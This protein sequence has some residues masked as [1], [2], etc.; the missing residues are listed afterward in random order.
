[1]NLPKGERESYPPNRSGVI[2]VVAPWWGQRKISGEKIL[3]LSS[4]FKSVANPAGKVILLFV[5]GRA[6]AIAIRAKKPVP[7]SAKSA[8]S[9]GE[10]DHLTII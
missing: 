9:F 5:E 4:I 10:A 3:S 8:G 1:M 2:G 6:A 7:K